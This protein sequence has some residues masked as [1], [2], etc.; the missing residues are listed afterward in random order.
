MSREV[1]PHSND[2]EPPLIPDWLS[3]PSSVVLEKIFLQLDWPS[4]VNCSRVCQ[5]WN[6]F[7]KEL[8]IETKIDRNWFNS[9]PSLDQEYIRLEFHNNPSDTI[10]AQIL[11]IKEDIK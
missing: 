2:E 11:H 10:Y 6:E 4:T 3:L 7:I 5:T 1:A 9:S 8:N